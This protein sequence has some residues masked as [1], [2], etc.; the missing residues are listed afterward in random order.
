[1]K[2]LLILSLFLS[3]SLIL[4]ETTTT[5]EPSTWKC[6]QIFTNAAAP[7]GDCYP[8]TQGTTQLAGYYDVGGYGSAE[9]YCKLNFKNAVY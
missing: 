4:T 8:P 9:I 6:A 3:I 1:M 2:T 7:S 5:T